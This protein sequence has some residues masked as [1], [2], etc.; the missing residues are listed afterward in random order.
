MHIFASRYCECA[1]YARARASYAGAARVTF[2]ARR[3]TVEKLFGVCSI[4]AAM[5]LPYHCP[6]PPAPSPKNAVVRTC[7]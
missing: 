7:I 2:A 5:A 3:T 6:R 1:D 4:Q